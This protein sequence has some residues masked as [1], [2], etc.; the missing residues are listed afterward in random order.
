[1]LLMY[2]SLCLSQSYKKIILLS[3]RLPDYEATF[4]WLEDMKSK[5][6]K[7]QEDVYTLIVTRL[8]HLRDPRA[9]IAMEEMKEQGY[10]VN[11][12]I[13]RMVETMR[14]NDVTPP[15]GNGRRSHGD[16]YRQKGRERSNGGGQ[17]AD[18]QGHPDQKA[19]GEFEGPAEQDTTR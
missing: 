18:G 16:T 9:R 14:K 7:P 13:R 3:S 10:R 2:T 8:A 11:G 12:D 17:V 19:A 1:M 6:I 4:H 5:G 15:R